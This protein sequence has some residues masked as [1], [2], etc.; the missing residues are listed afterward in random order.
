ME[1][2]APPQ[3]KSRLVE[4][5]GLLIATWWIVLTPFPWIGLLAF[6][7]IAWSVVLAV[8]WRSRLLLLPLVL[9]PIA[10]SFG[11]G[12]REWF[13]KH[14]E[15]EGMGLPGNEFFNLDLASRCYRSTGGCVLH[16]NEWMTQDPHNA[17]LNTMVKVLGPPRGVYQGPYPTKDE[18]VELTESASET[19]STLFLEGKVLAEDKQITIGKSRAH[20]ILADFGMMYFDFDLEETERKVQAR[21]FHQQCL[22][23]RVRSKTKIPSGSIV[24]DSEGIFL[25]D[26]AKMR[27]FARYVLSGDA[28]RVPRLLTNL[29]ADG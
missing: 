22:V 14:P 25:F 16:G 26:L 24:E 9:N 5:V 3:S 11:L 6:P 28:P 4:A 8:R 27:P 19:P 29:K 21:I 18:A 20:T 2:V 13:L 12:L 1:S 23:V 15:F 7:L 17:A 10:I